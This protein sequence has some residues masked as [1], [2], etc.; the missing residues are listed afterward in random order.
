MK[1]VGWNKCLVSKGVREGRRVG[2]DVSYLFPVKEDWNEEED[3][4][5]T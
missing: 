2:K 5:R 3:E 1:S 4:K